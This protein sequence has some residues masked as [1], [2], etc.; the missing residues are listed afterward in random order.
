M[1]DTIFDL[2]Q[3][4][5]SE[6]KQGYFDLAKNAPQPKE[7]SFF[8]DIADYGK[9]FLKGTIEGVSRLGRMM[10]PLQEDL[11]DPQRNL[12]EQTETLNELLPTDEGFVQSSIRRGLREAPSVMASP[13]GSALQTLPRALTAG[14]IGEGA[15]EL[16]APEWAQTAL[17]LTAYMG[18]DITKKLLASGSNKEIIDAARKFGMSDEAITPLLQSEFKQKWLSKLT[19][20]RGQ[21]QKALKTTQSSLGES[22]EFLRK[23]PEA[24]LEVTEKANGKL[25]NDLKSHL[26][27]MPRDVRSKISKDMSD[28]LNNKITPNSLMNFYKDV[29]ANLS[30]NTKQLSLLKEPIKEAIKSVSPELSKDFDMINNLYS[31][32][33][34]IASRLKPTLT[35]DI[36]HAAEILGITGSVAFGN[37][38]TLLGVLG[39]KTGRKLA[40]QMLINP[41][42]QQLSKKMT[43]AMNENKFALA[44]KVIEELN[45]EIRKVSPEASGKLK[46]LSLE[47]FEKLIKV[48]K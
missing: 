25:I 5:I 44:K 2:L 28:L 45:N 41:R 42:F 36:V 26:S 31:K 29:N 9:T 1:K 14:F 15:K 4:D 23:T 19:P 37:Y 40:Q 6:G 22:Y 33:S 7:K 32:Y 18:P 27:D 3:D 38:P 10:S 47:D 48:K 16:G 34:T 13:F 43:V 39:E 17:E 12:E 24:A 35:S 21:T 20:K 11:A 46:E 30:G 8:N